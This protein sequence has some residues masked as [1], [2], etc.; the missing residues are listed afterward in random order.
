M[1]IG[2]QQKETRPGQRKF[3]A[4]PPSTASIEFSSSYDIYIQNYY[5]QLNLVNKVR[6][7]C[8]FYK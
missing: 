3:C 6:F 1:V 2:A 5:C 8:G 4:R 7:N